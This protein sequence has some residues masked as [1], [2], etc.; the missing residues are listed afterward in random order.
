[1]LVIV[2]NDDIGI[3]RGESLTLTITGTSWAT[4][5]SQLIVPSVNPI[6]IYINNKII[7]ELNIK[8]IDLVRKN[9]SI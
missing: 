8:P 7:N 6:L 2:A 1:M 9:E 5:F 4:I 3:T